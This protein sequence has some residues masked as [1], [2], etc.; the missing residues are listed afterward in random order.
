MALADRLR[1]LP[2]QGHR[3]WLLSDNKD[4]SNVMKKE[5]DRLFH[6]ELA[7]EQDSWAVKA[8][9]S[10]CCIPA[11]QHESNQLDGANR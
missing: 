10:Y 6:Q 5:L 3:I 11:V 7:T 4:G 2:A 8:I 9:Y 1:R